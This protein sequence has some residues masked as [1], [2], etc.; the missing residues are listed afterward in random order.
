MKTIKNKYIAIALAFAVGISCAIGL[1]QNRQL[2]AT[3]E[4]NV[5]EEVEEKIECTA[6]VEDDFDDS[7]VLVV[8]DKKTSEKN[9]VYSTSS[10]GDIGKCE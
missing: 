2:M 6:T 4:E 7:S 5:A 9:K 10:F 3:A 8:L 1:T